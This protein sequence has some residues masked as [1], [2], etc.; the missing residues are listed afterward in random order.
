MANYSQGLY[1]VLNVANE[2]KTK[3]NL[4]YVGTELLV[5]G[6]LLTPKCDANKALFELGA[7][8]ERYFAYL[9]TTFRNENSGY[10]ENCKVALKKAGEIAKSTNSY[11]NT[12][13]LLMAILSIEGC[14]AY[15]ILQALGV[16]IASLYAKISSFAPAKQQTNKVS[17]E[18]IKKPIQK[19]SANPSL[20][21]LKSKVEKVKVEEKEIDAFEGLGYDLTKKAKEGKLNK[22]IGRDN[23]TQKIII[24]L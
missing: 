19:P 18:P 5:Y 8:H 2:I 14:R 9:K 10:T 3:Y 17:N 21:M 24:T 20:T 22:V 6:I 16:D 11:V 23:E 13:H 12:A 4:N 15:K 1:V 7:T